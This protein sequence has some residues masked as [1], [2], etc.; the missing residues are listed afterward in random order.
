MVANAAQRQNW[1]KTQLAVIASS[2]VRT[3]SLHVRLS[4][5]RV[6]NFHFAACDEVPQLFVDERI[7]RWRLVVSQH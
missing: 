3:E 7:Q 2:I 6:A 1:R 5:H 4:D